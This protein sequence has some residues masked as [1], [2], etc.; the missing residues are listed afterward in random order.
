MNKE[1]V[2]EKAG[3]RVTLSKGTMWMLRIA[4]LTGIVGMLSHAAQL[5]QSLG[6]F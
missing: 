3:E 1:D 6:I 4:A 5:L 2:K